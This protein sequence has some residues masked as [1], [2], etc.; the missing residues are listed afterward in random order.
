MRKRHALIIEDEILIALEIE[1]LLKK[2]GFDSVDIAESPLEALDRALLRKPD[3]ITADYR[4]VGGTGVEAVKMIMA[5]LGPIPVVYVTGHATALS[6]QN[7][8]MVVQKP[9]LPGVLAG[10]WQHAMQAA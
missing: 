3:L 5:H 4:I 1:D 9:I 8:D 2:Q 10:A 7:S 6:D